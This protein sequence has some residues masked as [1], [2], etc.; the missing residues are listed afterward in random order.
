MLYQFYEWNHA[1]LSPARAA[2]DVVRLYYKN[3]LNPLSHTEIGRQI[4]AAGDLFERMTRRYGKPEF[5]LD[6]TVVGG[7]EVAVDER[8]VWERPFCRLVHFHRLRP[9]GAPRQSKVVIV[10]PMSGHYSTL[11]RGTVEA[12]L[13][14]HEVYITDWVD[15]RMVPLALGRFDLDDY[16]DYVIAILE[17]LE[18]EAHLV[19]VCQPAV[20]VFAATAILEARQSRHLPRS[21]TLMGGPIDTRQSPTR[22]NLFA[23]KHD[24]DWFRRNAVHTAPYPFP[25][26]MRRVYPGFLQLSGFMTMNL[27][28][29]LNAHYDYFD[30]LVKGDG[31]SADK[32]REFYDE[33]SSV[34]DLTAEFYLQ[35]VDTV[36]LRQA[37]PKGEMKHRDRAV[38]PAAIT[39]TPILTIEGE[40]DD[41][42]GIGQTRAAH[43]LTPNLPAE[44]H[45]HYEQKDVGHYGVFNGS[46]FRRE[47]APRITAFVNRWDPPAQGNGAVHH[48]SSPAADT[49]GAFETLAAAAGASTPAA[50]P[51][52]EP[53]DARQAEPQD[54]N[55]ADQ[56]S[57]SIGQDEAIEAGDRAAFALASWAPAATG[58][59]E[60]GTGMATS[61]PST[62]EDTDDSSDASEGW[63]SAPAPTRT[64][65]DPSSIAL[66]AMPEDDATRSAVEPEAGTD[67][68]AIDT[69]AP[70]VPDAVAS[71]IIHRAQ[72]AVAH[73][74]E[75]EAEDTRET[76]DTRGAENMQATA[77]R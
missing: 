69:P 75:E 11:L 17:E 57:P 64:I 68:A 71:E 6:T 2:N 72:A 26:V 49:V 39:R 77:G 44:R 46:R 1:F 20:P 50:W 48:V 12:L 4:V 59:D 61:E 5:R 19:A 58:P 51:S 60:A 41:I 76:E 15:A 43:T 52:N 29:H 47:I 31:D 22:V 13:P 66:D 23:D 65:D 40:K 53:A 9:A 45:E 10:A 63:T 27:D 62:A 37:L 56:S 30:D 33:Y 38:D 70:A 28:R 55:A 32:H 36:F 8:I 16:I 21:I 14:H 74:A 54:L 7:V 24:L 3:P 35:T 25:G 42:S 73:E 67:R 34:M 18:G